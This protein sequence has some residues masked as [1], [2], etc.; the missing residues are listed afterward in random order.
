M[1]TNNRH[2]KDFFF[3]EVIDN[4]FL[5]LLF[6]YLSFKNKIFFQIFILISKKTIDLTRPQYFKNI[7]I[8]NFEEN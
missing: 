7:I 5:D 6:F 4:I 3:I 1:L 2:N 8:Q